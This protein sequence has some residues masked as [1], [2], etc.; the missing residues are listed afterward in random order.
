MKKLYFLFFFIM[1]NNLV[2]G[3]IFTVTSNQDS[4][5][6]TL[7]EAILFANANGVLNTDLINFNLPA[8][9][10]LDITIVLQS[11]LP[12]LNSNIIVDGTTQPI[13]FLLN[14]AI[15]IALV[16]VATTYFS[17]FRLDN[18]SSVEIYGLN[19]SNFKSDPLGPVDEK[20]GGIFLL[21]SSNI[22]IGAP[23]KPNSFGNNYAGIVSPFIIPRQDNIN[24]KISSNIF[25]LSENGLTAQPNES[26]IDIS[27]LTNSVI[28]GDSQAEGNLITANAKNGIALGGATG[29]IKISNNIIGLNKLLTAV[30]PSTKANGIYV[31]GEGVIPLIKNNI[32][33]GQL[34]GILLDYAN[35]GFIVA[36]NK[37]GTG[38]LGTENFGNETGIHVNFCNKGMIG[39]N[40]LADG[41][42]IGYNKTGV[43]IEI[44][45]P[46]SMLKNSFYC[47]STAAVT[48]KSIP[49]GK[50]ITQSRIST[51]TA[52]SAS[53]T[54]LPNS[55]LE[56]FYTDSCP[57]CQ[58]KTWFATVLTDAAGNWSYNG[59]ITGKITSMGTNSD[60]ATST[61]S[62]PQIDNTSAS[63]A[64]VVCGATTGSIE[65]DVYDASV[66]AWYNVNNP[67]VVVS[68]ER[69]LINVGAGTYFL[70]AGQN[71]LCDPPPS[72]NFTIDANAN[73]INDQQMSSNST[74]CGSKTGF[75]KGITI[76]NDPPRI[77]YDAN[78][79]EVGYDKDLIDQPPG[80]YYFK[81]G[82]GACTI[83][84][85]VY[86]I[87]NIVV[88]YKIKQIKLVNATCGSNNGSITISSYESEKPTA[89]TW[90]DAQNNEYATTENLTGLTPGKYKLVVSGVNGCSN[91]VGEYTIGESALPVIDYSALQKYISCDGKSV[92]IT[93]I[94]INGST[95]PYIA[96]WIDEN[97][98][99]VSN[100]LNINNVAAGKYTLS[101]TDKNGCL[102]NG[103]ILDF[104]ALKARTLSIPNSITPNGDGINDFWEIKG[105][106][107][108]PE[109]DFSIYSR[110]GN[111]IFYS[112]GYPKP[113]NGIYNGKMVP[114]GVYY[115][116][117]DLKTGCG[118]MSGSLTILR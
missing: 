117:I 68:T 78:G 27:F 74:Y 108:Y 65:V 70:R 10:L 53:G 62:K 48:F 9:G 40:T 94:K 69:K 5:P 6:G 82:V 98:N 85:K 106:Q 86:N 105:A 28:G 19:F 21:N 8:F 25:G 41:N 43:L 57:D 63:I 84:S 26:G 96:N 52:M 88:T 90:Y 50:V 95:D 91:T 1:W 46:I 58:G 75:I 51:I 73:G 83:T 100:Q 114:V 112:R 24:I 72:Q 38:P 59:P 3:A 109:S 35:G 66:F 77:W 18:A 60:G 16:R 116:V 31:N 22:I 104:E 36:S 110:D 42:S 7:R 4:G 30:L 71:G 76:A 107:N 55:T 14:P 13:S 12:I 56:L 111:R 17:G 67:T 54:Y 80:N 2:K 49:D 45:Y 47:N 103:Q 93:G 61:F 11:E 113:F 101:I 118:K 44:A 32:I 64:G 29:D 23:D 37:I 97:G 81:T 15:K 33:C 20:K 92:S 34:Q 39:G 89:F 79:N 102:V 99:S 87:P 115:Y